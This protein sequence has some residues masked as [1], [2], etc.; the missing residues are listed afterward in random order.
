MVMAAIIY[1]DDGYWMF[2]EGQ[3]VPSP[4]QLAALANGATPHNHE[5]KQNVQDSNVQLTSVV[6]PLPYPVQYFGGT[7]NQSPQGTGSI[8]S[9]A[10][11]YVATPESNLNT[12][13]FVSGGFLLALLMS[14]LIILSSI[15]SDLID[16][17][18]SN[19][20][21]NPNAGDSTFSWTYQSKQYSI[22]LEMDED[23]YDYYNSIERDCC[24]ESED[25]LQYF[26]PGADY[27]ENTA[28]T[29]QDLAISEGFTSSLEKA[30]FIL[31]F[32]GA[33]AYQFDP[34]DGFDHPKYPIEILWE[35]SGDCEDSSAL[36]ASLM[37]SLGYKTILVLL[38]TKETSTDEWG[39][40]ALVGIYIPNHTGD[41]FEL[42]G[43]FRPYY[44]AE[45]TA[46][47]DDY[48]AIGVNTWYDF[49][50]IETFEIK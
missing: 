4:K 13:L 34:D 38:D 46:W 24:Y 37:E 12:I 40:H 22:E 9:I 30:E 18:D 45:T 16:N 10:Y 3:W 33:I 27:V 43:D 20:I 50:N 44:I 11:Y 5:L 8:N 26:T 29:L 28:I 47:F 1:S 17:A 21:Y 2:V 15:S 35:H 25:Y 42:D 32:V 19:A 41:Y 36:Y 14:I 48:D 39:G 31:A 23:T 6:N 49:K 7:A